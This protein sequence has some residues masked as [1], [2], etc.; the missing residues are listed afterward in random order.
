MLLREFCLFA[1]E[2]HDG[3]HRKI[4]NSPSSN[5]AKFEVNLQIINYSQQKCRRNLLKFIER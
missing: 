1:E 2:P 5:G 4:E 3:L